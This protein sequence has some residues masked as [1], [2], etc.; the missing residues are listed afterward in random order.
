MQPLTKQT[1]LLVSSRALKVKTP[2]AALVQPL[3]C[4]NRVVHRD[5]LLW[6]L[7]LPALGGMQRGKRNDK[8]CHIIGPWISYIFGFNL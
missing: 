3:Y 6:K 8:Y 2:K 1:G 4:P 5:L 7:L